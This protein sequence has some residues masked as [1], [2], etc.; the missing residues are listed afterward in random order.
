[1]P[2]ELENAAKVIM[3]IFKKHAS[4]GGNPDTLE[5]S[6]L[7]KLFN[8]EMKMFSTNSF[9]K[10]ANAML[11]HDKSGDIDFSEFVKMLFALTA[12]KEKTGCQPSKAS[13]QKPK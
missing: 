9:D 12:C 4:K 10:L 7:K 2:T 11:E 13:C 5:I 3:D 1:M 8:D 6:E